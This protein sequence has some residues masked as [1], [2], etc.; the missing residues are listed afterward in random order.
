L[1][2]DVQILSPLLV[3]SPTAATRLPSESSFSER[4]KITGP[5][6]RKDFSGILLHIAKE[7]RS[8]GGTSIRHPH[9]R[10][11]NLKLL[12]KIPLS[13]AREPRSGGGTFGTSGDRVGNFGMAKTNLTKRHEPN[14]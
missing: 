14:D 3:K 4:W 2:P 12:S 9:L 10:R 13:I 8:G 6:Q 5:A 11:A 1:V 7:P